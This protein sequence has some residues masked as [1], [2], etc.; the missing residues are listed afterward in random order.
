[1]TNIATD[2]YQPPSSAEPTTGQFLD[3]K[4]RSTLQEWNKLRIIYNI[5][6]FVVGVLAAGPILLVAPGVLIMVLFYAILANICFCAGPF[7]DI[8][9]LVFNDTQTSQLRNV[10]FTLGLLISILITLS[11]GTLSRMPFFF[12]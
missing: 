12:W 9:Y 11:L 4:V 3:S 1:M 10:L 6:L 7:I 5:V 2:P 8:Y